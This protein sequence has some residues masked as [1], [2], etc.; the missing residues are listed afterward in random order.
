MNV[1]SCLVP[2]AVNPG[3]WTVD[4]RTE[5]LEPAQL[6]DP[7]L[8]VGLLLHPALH[9]V[10]LVPF[11]GVCSSEQSLYLQQLLQCRWWMWAAAQALPRR[12][13]CAAC[14]RPM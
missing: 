7:S 12:A 9:I 13:S 10:C 3:H 5:A 2:T 11:Q 4:M 8:K 14:R 6:D 1:R